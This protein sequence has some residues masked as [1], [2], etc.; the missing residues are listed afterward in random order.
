[1]KRK[2]K[3]RQVNNPEIDFACRYDLLSTV[4]VLSKYSMISQHLEIKIFNDRT[5]TLEF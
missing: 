3:G 2:N 5:Q 1:M 4:S